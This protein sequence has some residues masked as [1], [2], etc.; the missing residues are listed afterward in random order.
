MTWLELSALAGLDFALCN[1]ASVFLFFLLVLDADEVE[2]EDLEEDDDDDD[3]DDDDRF[4]LFFTG[5]ALKL[6]AEL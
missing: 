2:E 3:D 6:L 1:S 4:S 5:P